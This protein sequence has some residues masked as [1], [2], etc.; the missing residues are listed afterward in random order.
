MSTRSFSL[1]RLLLG[2]PLAS[3]QLIHEKISKIKA[4]A[5][6]SSDALSSVA[7]ATE[8][9]LFVLAAASTAAL[10]L[11]IPIALAIAGLL[12]TVGFSYYQTIHAYPKGGGVYLVT[13][14]NLGT[15]FSLI[16]GSALLID[17]TLTVAV[18]ISAGVAAITSWLPLLLPYR[19]AVAVLAVAFVTWMNLRGLR[20]SA[21]FFA[22]PT[23]L[24]ISGMLALIG[25]GLF[26]WITL[27]GLPDIDV[28]EPIHADLAVSGVTAFLI[29]RAFSAGCTALTGIEAISDGVPAFKAPE[30]D[31]AGKT[32]LVMITLL[33]TMFLGITFLA[34]EVGAAPSHAE[35]VLSQIGRSLFGAGP[36][37]VGV[38]IA[39]A[40]I[41][42]LAANTAFSDFPRLSYFM[43][44]DGYMPR[45]MGNLGDR[46]VFS[47][48]ITLLGILASLLIVIFNGDTHSLLPLYAVGVFI[49]FTLSQFGMV[50]RWFRLRTAGWQRNAM[51]NSLG[52]TATL[53][54][55]LIILTTRFLAGA[56][57]V[58]VL[59]TIFTL[60]LLRIHRHYEGIAMSLSLDDFGAPTRLRHPRVVMPIGGVHRGV[61]KALEFARSLSPDVTAVYV[62]TSTEEGEKLRQRWDRWGDG[63]RLQVLKSPYR[64]IV[65]PLMQ[66][67]N[68]LGEERQPGDVITVVL[69]QFVPEHWWEN[70]LHNQTAWPL[71]LA[72]LFRAGYIVIDVPYHIGDASTEELH[73]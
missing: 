41:L 37:Y 29:L 62:E 15:G 39:T 68:K 16:A 49:S 47:N 26:R 43:A 17:Y 33:T 30:A 64:S 12:I 67:L 3:S 54:V 28:I 23:Y 61:I 72:L 57:I 6:F 42:L 58:L 9:I 46:L 1:R 50:R 55:F 65:G 22:V 13:K 59:I 53:I 32:L 60:T 8:E 2:D 71:R 40:L 63:V 27:G 48:G 10:G 20:E 14:D 5:V 11:S 4:L 66:Y 25:F 24:F 70:L 35:T 45:Q 7:Y 21:S 73:P 56:W 38:Q 34:N 19:T 18:S 69:P 31:N 51:I 44:R 52:G 36:L